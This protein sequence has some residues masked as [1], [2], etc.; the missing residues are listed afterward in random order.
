MNKCGCNTV[1]YPEMV[2]TVIELCSGGIFNSGRGQSGGGQFEN[3]KV[4]V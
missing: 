3:W 2:S 4:Y 1:L